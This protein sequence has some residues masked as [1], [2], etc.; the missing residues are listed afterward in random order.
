LKILL[1]Q[2]RCS[3]EL[4]EEVFMHEPLALEY[5]GAGLK[6]DGHEVAL[7]DARIDSDI[8]GAMKK[9]NPQVAG[10]TGY[11]NQV[12]IV[13]DIAA[14]LKA[15]DPNVFVVVGGHH[16]TVRPKDFNEAFIDLIVI[17]EGVGAVR[18]I[19]DRLKQ[20]KN[21]DDILGLGIPGAEMRFTEKRVHPELD[22]LP[23]PD[24]TLTEKYRNDYFNEWLKP[25]ASIRT[26]L[27]CTSRC[28]FCA[29]W[30]ITD[31]KYLRRS[32]ESVVE[33]LKTIR[34]A[35]VFF[36]DDESMCDIRRMKQLGDA[37]REAG[38]QKE[39]FLYAR[40]DTII[41]HPELFKQWRD[42]GLTQVFVGMESFSDQRLEGLNKGITTAEQAKAVKILDELGIL[43]YAN[44][45]VDPAFD[46]D[47]FRALAR[48][49]R[50]LDLKYASFSVLTPLPGTA[51]Y[52]GRESELLTK[53]H[54][55]FDFMHT[56]L[57]TTLPLKEFYAELVWLFR[58][59][60][61]VRHT[62]GILRKYGVMR[63][64]KLLVKSPYLFKKLKQGYMDHE[65]DMC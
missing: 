55:M 33:E 27:G 13:K 7:I 34:E 31:G 58:N 52:D 57:P 30:A 43:L 11:T 4:S 17:G 39:F 42:I 48:Y 60:L 41:G 61:P 63:A 19:A 59:A 53:R 47:D 26:S 45:I 44:F 62:F 18:E 16:A 51:L 2:P 21:F 49:V 8:E 54:E 50:T 40:V 1:I 38:I 25:L 29:L 22:S 24:R 3:A 28:N 20:G 32:S 46:R 5:L 15:I 37:I 9:F 12:P 36:C 64:L 56:V 14:R 23:F 6:L 10:I 35:K 65:R